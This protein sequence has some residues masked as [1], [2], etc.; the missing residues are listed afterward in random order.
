MVMDIGRR[1]RKNIILGKQ[2]VSI[3][4]MNLSYRQAAGIWEQT[5]PIG[6]GSL[7]GLIWGTVPEERSGLNEESVW[8]G[9]DR[10]KNNMKG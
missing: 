10:D 8:S 7:G 6:N 9:Y 3:M 2:E 1:N 4:N 5:L